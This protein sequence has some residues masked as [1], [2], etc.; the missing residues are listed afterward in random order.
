MIEGEERY[1]KSEMDAASSVE[2][3]FR[4]A[5]ATNFESTQL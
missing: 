1:K 4:F 3:K 2:K 5:A